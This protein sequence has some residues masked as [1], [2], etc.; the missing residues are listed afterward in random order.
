M[1]HTDLDI[2]ALVVGNARVGRAY[3]W[4]VERTVG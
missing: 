3:G 2:G 4:L 1:A